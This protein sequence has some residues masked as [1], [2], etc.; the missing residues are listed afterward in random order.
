MHWRDA[1][2]QIKTFPSPPPFFSFPFE[3][4]FV[5]KGYQVNTEKKRWGGDFL[6]SQLHICWG[7]LKQLPEEIAF[8]PDW[9][10][11]GGKKMPDKPEEGGRELGHGICSEAHLVAL[12]YAF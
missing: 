2:G 8:N 9:G 7:N 5:L 1:N 4:S 3:E 6:A 11:G 10:G 12:S